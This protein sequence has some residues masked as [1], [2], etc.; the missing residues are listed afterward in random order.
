[1]RQRLHSFPVSVYQRL[2][3]RSRPTFD[4]ALHLNRISN[5]WEVFG[6]NELDRISLCRERAANASIVLGDATFQTPTSS[7]S[8]IAAIG[9]TQDV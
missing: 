3:L 2:F 7:A 8:V 9:A 4:P 6:K 1:M 5:R